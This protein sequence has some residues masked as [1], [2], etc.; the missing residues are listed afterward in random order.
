MVGSLL[1]LVTPIT[2]IALRIA[3]ESGTVLISVNRSTFEIFLLKAMMKDKLLDNS[4]VD[5][6]EYDS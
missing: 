2:I 6:Q 4:F 5:E 3:V 1:C